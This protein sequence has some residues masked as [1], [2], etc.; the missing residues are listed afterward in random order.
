MQRRVALFGA[1]AIAAVLVGAASAAPPASQYVWAQ[2]GTA[3]VATPQA[4]PPTWIP[5]AAETFVLVAPPYHW[6]QPGGWSPV[7]AHAQPVV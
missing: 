3:N 4:Q 6:A 1:S 5:T 7:T 2:P